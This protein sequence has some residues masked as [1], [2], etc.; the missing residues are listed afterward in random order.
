MTLSVCLFVFMA[1]VAGALAGLIARKFFFRP[2]GS[3][4]G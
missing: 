1:I 4:H 3:S 2:E